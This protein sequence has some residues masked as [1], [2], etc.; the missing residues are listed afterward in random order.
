MSS[1]V[2]AL[3]PSASAAVS[4]TW[5]VETPMIDDQAQAVVV[6]DSEAGNVYIIGGGVGVGG[7]S[8][9]F[10]TSNVTVYNVE[11]GASWHAAYMP[12][13]VRAASGGLGEDGRIYVFSGYNS[14]LVTTTQIYDIATDTWTTGTSMPSA[15]G[16]TSC[17][18]IWP[19]FYVMGGSS[20]YTTVEIY[21]AISDSWSGGVALPVNRWAG[22]AVYCPNDNSIFYIGGTD[23]WSNALDTVYR[24]DLGLSSWSPVNSMPTASDGPGAVLGM[25]GM[26]YVAGGSDQAWNVLGNVLNASSYYCPTNDTWTT[27]QNLSESRKY[28]GVV[29]MQDGL[30]LAL[31]GNNLTTTTPFV[32]S[33]R[34]IEAI[35][36]VSSTTI[37]QGSSVMLN[38]DVETAFATQ[39]STM[40][41]YYLISDTGIA[42][43][44][45]FQQFVAGDAS[46][47]IFISEAMPAGQYEL[48]AF[49]MVGFETGDWNVP[50]AVIA[51]TIEATIPLSQKISDLQSDISDLQAQLT[52][53]Q[54]QIAKL[55]ASDSQK[56]AD[57][58]SQIA[59]L[60]DALNGMNASSSQ[61]ISGLQDQVQALQD[62]LDAL[63]TTTGTAK[64][65]A[66]S[67][68][69]FAMIGMFVA[70][71]VL[72]LVIISMMM[73]RSKK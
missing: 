3:L 55:N 17:A 64:D 12:Q 9:A 60:Q 36:S 15:Q 22:Q 16:F 66:S 41:S 2:V 63:Q 42:Y 54:D 44:W 39:T 70:I 35:T 72:V 59:D 68:N 61:D 48:H 21:D 47:S 11:T 49:W 14:S 53:A 19:Y 58:E 7:G 27:L 20:F 1:F 26:I 52:A 50:E 67:A 34:P 24:F 43:P 31:G 46:I 45:N 6:A 5:T 28:L 56:I 33:I 32:E 62:K 25:D 38:L 73:S 8:Y 30:I 57:L 13:G 71:I 65:S 51:I 40:V 29:S 69:M 10:V 4:T 23:S 18:V 37:A